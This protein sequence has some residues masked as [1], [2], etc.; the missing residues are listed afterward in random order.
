MDWENRYLIARQ[1]L[2]QYE[3]SGLTPDQV[4][5]MAAEIDM[6]HQLI[7]TFQNQ[8]RATLEK[9][10]DSMNHEIE[11]INYHQKKLREKISKGRS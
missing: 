3:E 10:I 8:R 1:K 2:D 9:Q 6:L 5:G 7:L 4:R 11:L